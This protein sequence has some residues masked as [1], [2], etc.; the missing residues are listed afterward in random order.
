MRDYH[1]DAEAVYNVRQGHSHLCSSHRSRRY[2]FLVLFSGTGSVEHMLMKQFPNAKIVS[3]DV[4]PCSA[5]THV[6]DIRH[7]VD[8]LEG[9]MQ[10]YPPGYFHAIWAS[11][12]CTQYSVAKTIGRRDLASADG[13]AKAALQANSYLDPAY[14]Y[15]EN[16]VGL[17]RHREFMQPW[18]RYLNLTTYC[19]YGTAYMKLT[20][21]WTNAPISPLRRCSHAHPCKERAER[22]R[23]PVTAQSGPSKSGTPGS[24]SDVAVYLIPQK[25][26]AQ[27]F[28]PMKYTGSV[29][30][31]SF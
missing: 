17:L 26:L 6:C 21:I 22:G 1:E 23:H 15:L 27:L 16:P 31:T 11:P 9:G 8:S 10:V 28:A 5:A 20:C 18:N 30:N 24:G 3:L 29:A 13:L 4:D 7:W 2:R 25:L 12:P 14:W 19:K